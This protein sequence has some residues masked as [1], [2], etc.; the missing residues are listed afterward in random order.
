MLYVAYGSNMNLNQMKFRC[1]NSKIVGTGK[2]VGW[3][4]VFNVHL[5]IIQTHDKEDIVPVVIWDI[6]DEDWCTLDR[7]EG[8]P[9]YYIRKNVMVKLDNG[10]YKKAIVYVM[11]DSRKGIAPPMDKYFETCKQ[12]CIDNKID[13]EYLYKALHYSYENKTKYNQYRPKVVKG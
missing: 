1:P 6:A 10:K 3:K 13:V 5:D 4:L 8:Y 7:Y 12:G 11:V 2:L 9:Y